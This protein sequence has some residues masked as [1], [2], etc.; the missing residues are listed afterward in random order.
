MR[1]GAL[2]LRKDEP[3]IIRPA[4]MLYGQLPTYLRTRAVTFA[5]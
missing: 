1:P 2:P 5:E 3:K 4:V